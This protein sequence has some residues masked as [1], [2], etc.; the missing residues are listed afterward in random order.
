MFMSVHRP[1]FVSTTQAPP[2]LDLVT[3]SQRFS[4]Q[5]LWYVTDTEL[6]LI[7]E[8]V[9]NT[10]DEPRLIREPPISL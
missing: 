7:I 8:R 2:L 10:G 5:M 1:S 3:Y 4:L 9:V 6:P